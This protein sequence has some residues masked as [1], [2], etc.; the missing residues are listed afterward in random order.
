MILTIGHGKK[1]SLQEKYGPLRK[2][3]REFS[4]ERRAY[5]LGIVY[6]HFEEL[7]CGHVVTPKKDIYGETNAASR[8]CWKCRDGQAVEQLRAADGAKCARCG[9]SR[10]GHDDY[11]GKHEFVDPPRR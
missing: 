3:V 10:E 9:M 5:M 2:V 4:T 1:K 8:R 7:E 6:D 11:V